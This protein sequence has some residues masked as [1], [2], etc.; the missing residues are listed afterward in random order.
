MAADCR[1][2]AEAAESPEQRARC[3]ALAEYCDQMAAGMERPTGMV[4]RLWQAVFRAVRRGRIAART[5]WRRRLTPARGSRAAL[6]MPLVAVIAIGCIGLGFGVVTWQVASYIASSSIDQLAYLHRAGQNPWSYAPWTKSGGEVARTSF[7]YFPGIARIHQSAAPDLTGRSFSITAL[8]EIPQDDATGM[9]ITRGGLDGGWAFYVEH[10]KPVFHHNE[11]GGERYTIAAERPLAPGQHTLMFA[12]SHD[13]SASGGGTGTI[14]ANGEPLAQGRIEQT[15]TRPGS[16]DDE[17]LDI[18]EDTGTPVNHD[19]D[20][21]FKFTGKIVKVTID[22]S[23]PPTDF[24][25]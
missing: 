13:G 9:I 22:L 3:L 5:D 16:L 12:F 19:Y 20:V 4:V 7:T 14:L 24:D 11:A 23:V 18:G 15:G 1:R 10:G 17:G 25:D 2:R 6:A 21:P 8:L